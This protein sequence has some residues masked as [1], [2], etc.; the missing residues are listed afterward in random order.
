MFYIKI[1]LVNLQSEYYYYIKIFDICLAFKKF[2]YK[3]YVDLE[4]WLIPTYSW[5]D[6]FIDSVSYT[7][8]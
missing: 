3:L 4:L 1:L 6:L 2:Y 7:S 8:I 5:K